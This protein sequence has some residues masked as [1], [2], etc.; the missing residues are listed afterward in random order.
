MKKLIIILFLAVSAMQAQWYH[1]G[2]AAESCLDICQHSTNLYVITVS[3]NIYYSSTLGSNDGVWTQLP[4]ITGRPNLKFIHSANNIL[5]VGGSNGLYRSFDLGQTFDRVITQPVLCL[6]DASGTQLYLV[7]QDVGIYY[8]EDRFI[9]YYPK[10]NGITDGQ[11][12]KVVVNG[13]YV[14]AGTQNGNFYISNDSGNTWELKNSGLPNVAVWPMHSATNML[15]AS[16]NN[17]GIFRSNNWGN[18]WDQIG[19]NYG[20]WIDMISVGQHLCLFGDQNYGFTVSWDGGNNWQQQI[21]GFYPATHV[22]A[23]VEFYNFIYL[24]SADGIWRGLTNE[25]IVGVEKNNE[26]PTQFS[27]LQNYPNPF[28]P[29]TTISYALPKAGFVTLKVYDTAGREIAV[30]VNN[31]MSAGNYKINFDASNLSSGVYFYKLN[32]GGVSIA[33]KLIFMK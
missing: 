33:K 12:T 10:M 25:I 5:Y 23:A 24:A 6:A 28:N 11:I 4:E 1:N 19:A 17:R 29:A 21:Y 26:M 13:Q 32:A 15:F 16:S 7:I 3:G 18:S 14:F 31:E 27:L 2:L 9:S 20:N 30:L 8:S 22:K